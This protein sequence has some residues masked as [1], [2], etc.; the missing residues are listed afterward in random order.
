M[1]DSQKLSDLNSAA[2]SKPDSAP[3]GS[4]K[5]PLSEIPFPTEATTRVAN[6]VYTYRVTKLSLDTVLTLAEVIVRSRHRG[7]TKLILVDSNGDALDWHSEP[8]FI[9]ETVFHVLAKEYG[10]G[11]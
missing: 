3:T 1:E 11:L 5:E 10:L 4:T 9:N 7:T 6:E 2:R 8:V